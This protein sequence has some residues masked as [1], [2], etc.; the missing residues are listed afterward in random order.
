MG[1][2]RGDALRQVIAGTQL[3][4]FSDLVHYGEAFL[5][6]ILGFLVCSGATVVCMP[7]CFAV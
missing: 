2:R 3:A 4:S 7:L 5:K 1:K 6:A